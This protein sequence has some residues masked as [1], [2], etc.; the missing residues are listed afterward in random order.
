LQREENE[1]LRQ[2]INEIGTAIVRAASGAPGTGPEGLSEKSVDDNV[3][4]KATA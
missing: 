2:K 3:P 1:I 4:E